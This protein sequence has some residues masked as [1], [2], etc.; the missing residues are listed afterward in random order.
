MA[1][2]S[3]E[4]KKLEAQFG[5]DGGVASDTAPS[6][7]KEVDAKGATSSSSLT[8]SPPTIAVSLADRKNPGA[9]ADELASTWEHRAWV[10]GTAALLLVLAAQGVEKCLQVEGSGGGLTSVAVAL[11]AS[12][13]LSDFLTAVYHWSVDNYGDGSTPI[14]G[15]QIAA[16]QGHHQ[17]SR[18]GGESDC[19]FSF[20]PSVSR[21][22]TTL[23][24]FLSLLSPSF[25][26]TFSLPLS[27]PKL[28]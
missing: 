1:L 11:G 2:P 20:F 18:R 9:S 17:V 24:L 12:Y 23:P 21:G 26:L 8:S 14:V 7:S 13:L 4:I 6:S 19:L 10:A 5:E 25:P 28:K 22:T 15:G 27:P 16:F 3:E